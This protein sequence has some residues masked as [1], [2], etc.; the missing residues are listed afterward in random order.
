MHCRY[1]ALTAATSAVTLITLPMLSGPTSPTT[2][3]VLGAALACSIANW[4]IVGPICN[5]IL[6]ER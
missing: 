2:Q 4:L 5:D 1:F 6:L 3:A